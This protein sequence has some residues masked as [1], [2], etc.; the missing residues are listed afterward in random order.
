MARVFQSIVYLGGFTALGYVL[1]KLTEPNQEKINK[2]RKSHFQ[3]PQSNENQRKAALIIQ[4]LKEA[5]YTS[6]PIYL[7]K[8]NQKQKD[9]QTEV[10]NQQ[11]SQP[12]KRE[13]N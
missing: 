3:D 12:S 6:E 13:I 4:K 10:A 11:P 7:Q 1:L 8:K 2:I 5:A 9:I